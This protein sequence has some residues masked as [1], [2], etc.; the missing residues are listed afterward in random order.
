[1]AEQAWE[2]GLVMPSE[3]LRH[4]IDNTPD[5][6]EYVGRC[7]AR[8]VVGDYGDAGSEEP[9]ANR[10]DLACGAC[11]TE[12]ALVGR[13]PHPEYKDWGIQI[14]TEACEV[15]VRKTSVSCLSEYAT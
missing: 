14:E 2:I 7:M 11:S 10:K 15:V 6:N 9:Q 13:Y 5:F 12:P 8:Y 3:S 4:M 1:M